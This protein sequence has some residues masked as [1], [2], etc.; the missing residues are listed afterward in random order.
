M[1]AFGKVLLKEQYAPWAE[2]YLDY[3]QL[4]E[5]LDQTDNHNTSTLSARTSVTDDGSI[6]ESIHPVTREF[7]SVLHG[8]LEKILLFVLQEQGRIATQLDHCRQD[9]WLASQGNHVLGW[10]SIR[11]NYHQVGHHLLRL[12]QFVN[13]NVTGIRKILKKHD[14]VLRKSPIAD[15]VFWSSARGGRSHNDIT[16][17]DLMTDL[18][19]RMKR[20]RRRKLGSS[21]RLAE[22]LLSQDD[23]FGALASILETGLE[24]VYYW[25][26]KAGT[27]ASPSAAVAID[28]PIALMGEKKGSSNSNMGRH[29]SFASIGSSNALWAM[30]SPTA[31]THMRKRSISHSHHPTSAVDLSDPSEVLLWRIQ[32]ARLSLRQTND[33]VRMLAA[34]LF[35]DGTVGLEEG[36]Q[37][38]EAALPA[39]PSRIS[40]V[41]NLLSTFLYLTNYFIIAP[42]CGE[43][44]SRLGGDPALASLIIGMT[45]IAALVST[46][47]FSWWTNHSYK[48]AIVFASAC[49]LVGNLCY[50]MGLPRNSLTLVLVGR[51]LNGFGSARSIN[52]RY[53]ADAFS[54]SERTSAS[55]TFVTAGALGMASGPAI[56]SLLHL[57][58]PSKKVLHYSK[59]EDINLYWQV[60]NAPGWFMMA[61]WGTFLVAMILFFQDPPRK[62]EQR[63]LGRSRNGNSAAPTEETDLLSSNCSQSEDPPLPPPKT[64]LLSN[65]PVMTTFLLYFV[66]KLILEI[67]SSSCA[68]ITKFYFGWD[69]RLTGVYLGA[70]G[71]LMIPVNLVVAFLATRFDDRELMVALLCAMLVGC[72]TV[73]QYTDDYPLWQYIPS[74][75][76]L[77]LSATSLE[78]PTMSLLSKTIP[79]SWS[80]GL[81]NVGLLATEAGTLGRVVGDSLLSVLGTQGGV[82]HVL[83]RTFGVCLTICCLSIV[84]AIT[85]FRY[86]VPRDDE[87]DEK[88]G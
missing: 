54:Y 27:V 51:L 52:R 77:F 63:Q 84:V 68:T 29:T 3:E 25:D 24:T 67:I 88:E 72:I 40:N 38:P 28:V 74:S 14:K 5:V 11:A 43:Y 62:R 34:P 20:L 39:P 32:A 10:D 46:V 37:A 70:M 19:S 17:S 7:L 75:V 76:V 53:I 21:Y 80:R 31:S 16:P 64:S 26:P 30:D 23:A 4:K 55:A 2:H 6:D 12:V 85:F 45:P 82:E 42:T 9:S 35:L 22:P 47:L 65:T 41:L 71:L 36:D 59:K 60:E 33:V 1:V 66:L 81:L 13:L 56:A 8:Q 73:M 44:A 61:M 50:A 49:S 78:G 79:S 86:L 48:S 18:Q 69:G 58:T 83:N 15:V 57:V 87:E